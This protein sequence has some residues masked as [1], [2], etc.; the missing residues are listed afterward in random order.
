MIEDDE[1]LHSFPWGRLAFNLTLEF[2]KRVAQSKGPQDT[3]QGFPQ[4]LVDLGIQ[5]HT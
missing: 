3:L 4:R 1:K 5:N 2:V